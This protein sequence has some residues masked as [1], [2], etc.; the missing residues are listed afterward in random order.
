MAQNDG[1]QTL[2]RS[3]FLN[4]YLV[5]TSESAFD[6]IAWHSWHNLPG[7]STAAINWYN[8]WSYS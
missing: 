4:C 8:M 2:N 6:F 3:S 5:G 1:Q 7:T